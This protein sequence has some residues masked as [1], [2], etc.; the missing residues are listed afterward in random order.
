MNYHDTGGIFGIA[1]A[2][3]ALSL[4]TLG[5]IQGAITRQNFFKAGLFMMVNGS[6]AGAAAYLVGWGI[7]QSIG[8]GEC[9]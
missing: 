1:A 5:A 8:V 7:E 9:A 3:T 6:L 4:F 2:A